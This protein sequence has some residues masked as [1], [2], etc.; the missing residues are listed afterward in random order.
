MSESNSWPIDLW[1][2]IFWPAK[3]GCLRQWVKNASLIHSSAALSNLAALLNVLAHVYSCFL[4]LSLPLI[5]VGIQTRVYETSCSCVYSGWRGPWT[6]ATPIQLVPSVWMCEVNCCRRD[7]YW[8]IKSRKGIWTH[9]LTTV[10]NACAWGNTVPDIF[11]G[12]NAR[13]LTKGWKGRH[14]VQIH[15][16]CCQECDIKLNPKGWNIAV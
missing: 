4:G 2:A 1:W 8:L 5:C 7:I 6:I 14:K 16:G 11:T 10:S 12:F 15:P 13:F 3:V 9:W